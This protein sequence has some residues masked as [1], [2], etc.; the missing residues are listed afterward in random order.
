[1]ENI[2]TRFTLVAVD[3]EHLEQAKAHNPLFTHSMMGITSML[4]D[5][6]DP[7]ILETLGHSSSPTLA[8]IFVGVM[9]QETNT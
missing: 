8:D 2:R 1:M 7:V 6:V 9:T 4:F 5:N 3:N